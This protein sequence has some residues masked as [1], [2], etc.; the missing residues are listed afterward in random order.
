MGSTPSPWWW[1]KSKYMLRENFLKNHY[2][3]PSEISQFCYTLPEK[4]FLLPRLC[5]Y[6]IVNCVAASCAYIS[7]LAKSPTKCCKA[8]WAFV[9]IKRY[10]NA[11]IIV[12]IIIN[13]KSLHKCARYQVI[14]TEF[15][16]LHLSVIIY[17]AACVFFVLKSSLLQSPIVQPLTG[18]VY[19]I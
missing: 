6:K 16:K 13:Y 3:A 15:W 18:L 4:A 1:G 7:S 11:T 5:V 19:L 9:G 2:N 8:L 10:I 17:Q 12:I 14:S